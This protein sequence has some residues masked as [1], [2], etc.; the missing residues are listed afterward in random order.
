MAEIGDLVPMFALITYIMSINFREYLKSE[1]IKEFM[2][3]LKI[4]LKKIKHQMN[5]YEISEEASEIITKLAILEDHESITNALK[6]MDI[7]EPI[8]IFKIKGYIYTIYI[9]I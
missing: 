1:N 5:K 9:Y 2:K 6:E 8:N 3:A 4:I 7:N